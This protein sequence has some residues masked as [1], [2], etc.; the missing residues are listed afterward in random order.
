LPKYFLMKKILLIP[1]L[2]VLL[3]SCGSDTKTTAET[4]N[5]P[6]KDSSLAFFGDTI[7]AEGAIAA[8]QVENNLKGKD[9]VALKVSG[10]IKDVCQKKGCWMMMDIGNNKTMRVTFKDYAFFVPKD[11]TG[12]N[13]I[14]EGYAYTDTTTV[15]Q[16]KH[17]AE[18]AG[19][20]KS[21][22]DTIKTPEISTSFE[23]RGVI[24][25]K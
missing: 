7:S 1:A 4:N 14:I 2:S 25:K 6:A 11:G 5:V 13:A 10:T 16:L 17:Y 22:I 18:D 21:V 12:S 9:S 24:I 15:A 8:S 19:S 3:F 20:P 23:A